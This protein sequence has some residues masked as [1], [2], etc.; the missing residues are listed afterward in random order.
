MTSVKI[1]GMATV[2]VAEAAAALKLSRQ[3]VVQLINTGRLDA[4][5]LGRSWAISDAELAA[6]MAARRPRVR[7]MTAGMARAMVDLIGQHL[8]EQAGPSW[9]EL[10]D[11]ERSRLRRRWD[12]LTASDEPASLLRAWLPARC[13]AER[14]SFRG[15]RSELFDDPRLRAGGAAHPALGLSGGTLVEPH[16]MD[17]DREDVI[18]DLLLLP[19]TNG[20]VLLRSEPIARTDLAACIADVADVG[21]GR[22]DQVVARLLHSRQTQ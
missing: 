14:F 7:P 18:W 9:L 5:R 10:P 2:S 15:D 17:A 6:F 19:A 16:V 1:N 4:S 11:R 8:G 20:N 12:R 22:N 13:R 21:G 3:R